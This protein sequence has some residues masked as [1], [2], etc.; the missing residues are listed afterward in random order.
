MRQADLPVV[1]YGWTLD[2]QE[3]DRLWLSWPTGN[4]TPCI[5]SLIHGV[6]SEGETGS[7]FLT[8][9]R[10]LQAGS[11]IVGKQADW[12]AASQGG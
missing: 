3:E 11:G 2:H 6:L 4:Y 1:E 10:G 12:N 9:A 5:P 8:N 7:Q